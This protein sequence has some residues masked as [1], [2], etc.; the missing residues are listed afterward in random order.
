MVTCKGTLIVCHGMSRF[1]KLSLHELTSIVFLY[2]TC[3][4]SSLMIGLFIYPLYIGLELAYFYYDMLFCLFEINESN[5][6]TIFRKILFSL[7]LLQFIVSFKIW[8]CALVL[9]WEL[10]CINECSL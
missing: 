5:A 1:I 4:Y 10:N 7:M 2:L 6:L 8:T 9:P 3:W